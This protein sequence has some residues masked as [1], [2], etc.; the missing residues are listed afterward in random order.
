MDQLKA[1]NQRLEQL[2]LELQ[3]H[4]DSMEKARQLKADCLRDILELRREISDHEKDL[5]KQHLPACLQRICGIAP[6][7]KSCGAKA[8]EP[9]KIL[10]QI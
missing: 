3:R 10:S 7:A 4:T 5:L 6:S 1:M 2:R 9:C 8:G